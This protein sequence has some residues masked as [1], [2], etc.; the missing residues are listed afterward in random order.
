LFQVAIIQYQG[1]RKVSDSSN[2]PQALRAKS[3]WIFD[4]DGTL[5]MPVHDFAYIRQ[6]LAIPADADILEHL[7]QLPAAEATRRQARLQE[8]ELELARRAL[9]SPGALEMIARLHQSGACLGILTRNDREIALLTLDTI[10][11][12]HYFADEHVLGRSD[13][14]PKPDP[15]GIHLLLSSWGAEPADTVMVGDYLFDLQ[16]G[17]A[18]GATTVHVGRPDGKCW[19]E[20]TDL[21]VLDL[22]ELATHLS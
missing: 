1:N 15:D 13:A 16:A 11:A 21:A 4:L 20:V 2:S 14:L 18:A 7:E 8:I 5:T 17:R 19:P 9:P 3:Y 10:G 12:R 6:E 22:A